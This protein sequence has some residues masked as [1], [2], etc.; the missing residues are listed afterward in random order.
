MMLEETVL[1]YALVEI[2]G[3]TMYAG[4]LNL[5][6]IEGVPIYV[7]DV[8]ATSKHDSFTRYFS[9]QAMFGWTLI[10]ELEAQRGAERLDNDPYPTYLFAD[11]IPPNASLDYDDDG[12][13]F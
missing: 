2:M 9:T 10:T 5:R 4:H 7:L 6:Q 8:P 13:P 11:E 12:I 3:H 1:G